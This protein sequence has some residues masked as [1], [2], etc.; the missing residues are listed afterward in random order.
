[1][2]LSE[3]KHAIAGFISE[4]DAPFIYEKVGNYFDKFMIDEFQDTSA[5]EWNNFLPLLRNAMAQSTDTSVLIVGD[6]KQSIYRWRGGDWRILGSEIESDLAES[7]RVPL[8]NNWRSL[9]NI[10]EF[11]NALFDAVIKSENERLNTLLNEADRA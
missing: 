7:A 1:M 11:N 2:L 6:V 3:T 10:V 8:K 9:P 4:S 5:K